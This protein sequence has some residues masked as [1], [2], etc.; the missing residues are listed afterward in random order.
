M[1]FLGSNEDVLGIFFCWWV[2]R[3]REAAPQVLS[4]MISTSPKSCR[5]KRIDGWLWGEY[6]DDSLSSSS[7]SWCLL[8]LLLLLLLLFV[9]VVVVLLRFFL[10]CVCRFPGPERILQLHSDRSSFHHSR[11]PVRAKKKRPTIS[12]WRDIF[13]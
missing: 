12:F 5:R 7:S 8:L 9:A 10:F 11:G 1:L 3:S 6:L 13:G 2:F 4:S